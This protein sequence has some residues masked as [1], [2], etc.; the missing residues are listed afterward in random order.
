MGVLEIRVNGLYCLPVFLG[1][2]TQPPRP[3]QAPSRWGHFFLGRL[4]ARPCCA[5]MADGH[6]NAQRKNARRT[7][8]PHRRV[9]GTAGENFCSRI[10][11][12][13]NCHGQSMD[14]NRRA[15]EDRSKSLT[16]F[17]VLRS[18]EARSRRHRINRAVGA[19]RPRSFRV[20]ANYLGALNA[21]RLRILRQKPKAPG[22]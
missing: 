22:L 18:S 21:S 3:Q 13:H 20:H 5:S 16:S 1:P 12:S 19:I 4:P 9:C 10:S 14:E 15:S 11:R 2:Q 8:A 6:F 7:Q 17:G